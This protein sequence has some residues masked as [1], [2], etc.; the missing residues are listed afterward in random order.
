MPRWAWGLAGALLYLEMAIIIT[1]KIHLPVPPDPVFKKPEPVE[2]NWTPGPYDNDWDHCWQ[3]QEH[4][5]ILCEEEQ[6]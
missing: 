6:I 1:W 4:G 3:E 2:Y 5:A